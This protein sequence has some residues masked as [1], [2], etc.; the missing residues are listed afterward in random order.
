VSADGTRAYALGLQSAQIFVID[1]VFNVRLPTIPLD[2]I[3]GSIA[4]APAG[5]MAYVTFRDTDELVVIDTDAGTVAARISVGDSPLDVVVT[6]DGAMAYVANAANTV[7]AVDLATR[8]VV[9]TIPVDNRPGA[10]AIAPDD[11]KVYVLASADHLFVIDRATSTVIRTVDISGALSALAATPNGAFVYVA[12]PTSKVVVVDPAAGSVTRTIGVG[13]YPA[14]IGFTPDGAFA[15]VGSAGL[16]P[17]G[18]SIS[19]IDAQ[20]QAVAATIS[21][22][23]GTTVAPASVAVANILP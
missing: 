19:V 16:A 15:Y 7:S 11:S 23:A 17:D 22:P 4:T 12:N 13:T 18:G 1:T 3:G 2:H 9:T 14:G 6:H 8:A 5:H 21:Y 10:I 20:T